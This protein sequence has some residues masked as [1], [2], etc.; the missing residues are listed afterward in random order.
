MFGMAA[1]ACG[2]LIW[3]AQVLDPLREKQ[4]DLSSDFKKLTLDRDQSVEKL[5]KLKEF[6]GSHKAAENDLA[7]FDA[8]KIDGRTLEELAAST[9]AILQQFLEKHSIPIKAYK[10]LPASKWREH[11]VST[12]EVQIDTNMQGL[13]DLLEFLETMNKAVRIERLTIA[14]RRMKETD[15]LV[16]LQITTLQME[17]IKP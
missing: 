8:L 10:D 17:G 6:I 1:V 3:W 2:L 14:Y 16:S 4:N 15:L 7:R 5:K 11:P 12:I 9:Q 13:S